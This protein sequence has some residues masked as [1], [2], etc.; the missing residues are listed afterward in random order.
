[1]ELWGKDAI[2]SGAVSPAFYNRAGESS[3]PPTVFQDA[4]ARITA[5]VCCLGCRHPHLLGPRNVTR[6]A[7]ETGAERDSECFSVV[8]SGVA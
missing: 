1:M 2:F 3:L 7:E 4:V 6:L 8:Q 5:A